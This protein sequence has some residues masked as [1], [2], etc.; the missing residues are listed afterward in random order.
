MSSVVVFVA[1]VGRAVENGFATADV[2]SG[3]MGV[4]KLRNVCMYPRSV[5]EN[6]EVHGAGKY[7][8]MF[9]TE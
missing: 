3:A 6:P 4:G 5:D 9:E 2:T 1:C 7:C 8:Y